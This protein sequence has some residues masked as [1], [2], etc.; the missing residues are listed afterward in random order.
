MPRRTIAFFAVLA[1]VAIVGAAITG[2][3]LGSASSLGTL[4]LAANNSLMVQKPNGTVTPVARVQDQFATGGTNDLSGQVTTFDPGSGTFGTPA[5]SWTTVRGG[6]ASP[7]NTWQETG[8]YARR[9]QGGT[10][11]TNYSM[12]L[13]PWLTRKSTASVLFLNVSNSGATRTRA[14]LVLNSDATGSTGI[15]A[16]VDCTNGGTCFGKLEEITGTNSSSTCNT[17]PNPL[18]N[19]FSGTADVTIDQFT[20]SDPGAGSG[21]VS[22]RFVQATGNAVQTISCTVS[23]PPNGD[24]SGMFSAFGS[25]N[26]QFDNLLLAYS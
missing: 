17:T 11:P 21:N 20:N 12:A 5:P 23:N 19:T 15:V 26:T 22:A 10:A 7:A 25:D 18:R 4:T 24:R 3:S 13:V 9:Q 6:G 14:G 1:T 2:T 8:G 16:V